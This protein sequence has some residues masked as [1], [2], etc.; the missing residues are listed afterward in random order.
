VPWLGASQT[1][2]PW[3][4]AR[5]DVTRARHR[6]VRIIIESDH[7]N[8]HCASNASTGRG[9]EST[10][11]A[12]SREVPGTVGLRSSWSWGSTAL[13]L[14]LALRGKLRLPPKSNVVLVA[15]IWSLFVSHKNLM[16][17]LSQISWLGCSQM[18][19]GS[20]CPGAPA[21][22]GAAPLVGMLGALLGLEG[23]P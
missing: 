21:A 1:C 23:W 9:V 19:Y 20:A 5:A 15:T 18:A 7:S 17:G 8:G 3:Q 13:A 2:T 14:S 22:A 6:R 4:H 11:S 10:S 12:S 16:G